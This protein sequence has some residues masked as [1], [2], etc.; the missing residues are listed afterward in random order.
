MHLHDVW[1]VDEEFAESY[2]EHVEFGRAEAL[3]SRLAIVSICRTAMPHLSNTLRLVADLAAY[4]RDCRYFVYEND[5]EDETALV[6]D[7]F[8]RRSWVEVEIGRAHV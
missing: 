6:L 7:E 1:A 3:R 4:W 2:R 8:A 5:S